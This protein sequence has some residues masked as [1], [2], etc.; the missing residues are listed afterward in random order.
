[1]EKK[2]FLPDVFSIIGN[3]FSAVIVFIGLIYTLN[4]NIWLSGFICLVLMI[5]NYVF[6][7]RMAYFKSRKTKI[8]QNWQEYTLLVFFI[9]MTLG[10]FLIGTHFINIDIFNKDNVKKS[11]EDK[12]LRIDQLKTDYSNEID[13][14]K[15]VV[16]TKA[17][18]FFADYISALSIN[19]DI[20]AKK[21]IDSLNS[22]LSTPGKVG[23]NNIDLNNAISSKK[24]MIEASLNLDQFQND[25]NFSIRIQEA[26]DVIENWR[27]LK[28]NYSYKDLD[29]V[30]NALYKEAKSKIPEFE[31]TVTEVNEFNLADPFISLKD[32]DKKAILL[33][34]LILFILNLCILAPYISS[35]RYERG[36]TSGSSKK[37]QGPSGIEL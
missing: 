10:I 28:L 18:I 27:F 31:P 3:L 9:M 7:E 12:I 22:L 33:S 37:Y 23:F 4:G 14:K 30:Y 19:D 11:G 24:Q 36:L 13:H 6:P 25:N 32:G 2:S 26:K 20:R 21:N 16:E 1:M 15:S 5:L 35:K 34:V 8:P 29:S 17:N